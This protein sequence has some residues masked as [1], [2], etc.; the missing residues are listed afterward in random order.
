MA[1]KID[2]IYF[3][4]NC[5]TCKKAEAFLSQ[6]GW[7]LGDQVVDS[8]KVR[9]D[10]AEAIKIVRSNVRLIVVKGK[11]VKSFKLGKDGPDDDEILSLVMGPTG[12]LRSPTLR[13]GR[14]IVV[15]F[16]ESAYQDALAS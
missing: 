6:I 11:A 16:S 12:N 8:T 13:H 15:G 9:K 5:A 14:T 4:K 1:K 10:G 7:Q 2:W 3:R